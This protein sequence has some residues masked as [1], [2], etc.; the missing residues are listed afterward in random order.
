NDIVVKNEKEL[1]TILNGGKYQKVVAD[2]LVEQLIKKS[3]REKVKFFPM[4]HVAVSS[5]I[6]WDKPVRFLSEDFCK[7]IRE[8]I[9]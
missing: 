3:E 6:Y 2:P 7:F 8:I 9:K 5:K 1:R 4:A